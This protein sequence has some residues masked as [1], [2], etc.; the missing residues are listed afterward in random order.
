MPK[1]Y[2]ASNTTTLIIVESPSKC[3]KIESYLG[4][5]YKCLATCGHLRELV[6]LDHIHFDQGQVSCTYTVIDTPT[7]RKAI[8]QLR[9]AIESATEV[10]LGADD[11]REGEAIAWH[12]CQLF[13]LDVEQTKRIVFHEITEQ[14]LQKAIRE[15]RL[16]NM[17]LVKAQQ[18][19]QVLDLY[20]G[21][22]I[23]PLLWRH[24][25]KGLSKAT[26]LSAGRCQT[27][28][29]KLVYDNY[30][31]IATNVQE[32]KVYNVTG[33]FT[34]SNL[35]FSLNKNIE[36]ENEML[37]FLEESA[38][39][40]H[41]YKCSAPSRVS[42]APPEPFSTSRLQQ[43]ASNELH[44]SPKETMRVCQQLYEAGYITYMRTDSKVYSKEFL[45]T[46][47]EYIANTFSSK[48][49]KFYLEDGEKTRSSISNSN[50]KKKS[51]KDEDKAHE[52]IRPTHISLLELPE[53]VED[54]KQRRL[55]KL[56][57]RNTLESCMAPA[58]Y[59]SVTA[60]I[61][62]PNPDMHYSYSA[63]LIEF[64]GWKIVDGSK[65]TR[66]NKDFHYLQTIHKVDLRIPY[67][68]IC[69]A[70]TI[71][72]IKSHYTE[73]R[74]VQELEARGIGRPSTFSSLVDK[75]QERGYV[76]K[77]DVKGKELVCKD[78]ELENKEVFEIERKREFGN[79]K[80]KLVLQPLGM[81]VSEYLYD[82]FSSLFCF[83]YTSK[84][85][86]DLDRIAQ[87]AV[88][89]IDV[90]RQCVQEVDTLIAGTS[91]K[92]DTS[93]SIDETH[94]YVIG[95]Y[96]P[97][98]KTLDK[99]EGK[100]TVQFEPVKEDLPLDLQKLRQGG[101]KVEDIRKQTKDHVLGTFEGEN[102]VLKKGKFGLYV[103]WGTNSRNLKELGNR[104]IENITFEEVQALL[105][106]SPTTMVREI[107]PSMSI[108]TGQKG[109]YIFY[110]PPRLKKPQFFSL[111]GF[112]EDY[113]ICDIAILKSWIE[114]KYKL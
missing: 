90:C 102:I 44:Y 94:S 75:I 20:V 2:A 84:M 30:Q 79:E 100:E 21:F 76:K 52:A 13:H 83:E 68:K 38:E 9:K 35:L 41:K 81:M 29:L 19:R 103:T 14:A 108:R 1:K 42:K 12:V 80:G 110:K 27:P 11:D 95:K 51:G 6:S 70:V 46:V 69:A 85:E 97:V 86:E 49:T 25:G 8:D 50:S 4:P 32:R 54:S 101:Y 104:P 112:S 22:K 31:D 36:D 99:E 89:S 43:V 56:I 3:K 77:C 26:A 57:W 88:P 47:N 17:D 114:G 72:G 37:D 5:G 45:D 67:K 111:A 74:L 16:L 82:H 7:K 33:Y 53:E 58:T 60:T 96:G 39:F 107:T 98:I 92:I 62:C 48:E 71:R 64:P 40:E 15:P 91:S 93:I 24:K 66:E 105:V 28:A 55:Y 59:L 106:Q 23:S 78:F 73:A 87:G 61:T 63:E 18:A 113:K 65:L 109:D 34:S 10:L